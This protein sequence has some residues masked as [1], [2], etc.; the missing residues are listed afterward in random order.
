[1]NHYQDPPKN[2]I[3][4]GLFLLIAGI[5]VLIHKLGAPIPYWVFTTGTL[6]ISI[7]LLIGLK[8]NFKNPGA[9]IVMFIGGIFLVSEFFPAFDVRTF[10]F[11]I[12]LIGIGIAFILRPKMPY[13]RRRRWNHYRGQMGSADFMAKSPDTASNEFVEYIDVVAVFSGVKKNILSKNFKGGEV[14]CF[15][16]GAEINLLQADIQGTV[17]LDVTNV[18]G[19]TELVIPAHWHLQNDVTAV[20]GAV[21]DKRSVSA[22][23]TDISKTINLKGT[24]VFGGIEI[25]SY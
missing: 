10:I 7:G 14:T 9:F 6:L 4:T 15:M 2:R 1:M 16:G 19:G 11:P 8:S 17:V 22:T 25:K 24:C 12:I 21:E 20:F 13:R 23:I 3:Y 5:L 18:F